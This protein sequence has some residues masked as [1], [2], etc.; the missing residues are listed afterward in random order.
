MIFDENIAKSQ[1]EGL[2][3]GEI[4]SLSGMK[5]AL[6]TDTACI[7][8]DNPNCIAILR[9]IRASEKV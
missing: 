2:K 6:Q 8:G 1:F 4:I 9:T 5:K 3:E 7:H